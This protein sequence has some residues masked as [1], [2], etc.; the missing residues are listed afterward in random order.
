MKFTT[1]NILLGLGIAFATYFALRAMLWTGPVERGWVLVTCA[2]AVLVVTLLSILVTPSATTATPDAP[3]TAGSRGPSQM[4][5]GIA[6]L[7][8]VVAAIV[9]TAVMTSVPPEARELSYATTFLGAIGVLLTVVVI[10]RRTR[11][12]WCGVALLA[13]GAIVWL[14]PHLALALGLTGS[15]MW[16]LTAQLLLRGL[17]RLARDSVRLVELQHAA[18]AWGRSQ[19]ARR[20]ERRV[21]VQFALRTAGPV[22]ERVIASG[23]ELNAAERLQARVAEGALRDYLR[24][25]RLLDQDVRRE[26]DAARARGIAVTMVDDGGLD[27]ISGAEL[28]EIRQQLAQAIAGAESGRLIIRTSRRAETAVSVVGRSNASDSDE[29]DVSL[30]VEIAR[31]GYETP[32]AS[33]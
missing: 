17:D 9:P 20:R 8:I 22:L 6:M 15:V 28:R 29:D 7:S 25:G 10:R 5:L 11:V 19:D 13:I 27:L 1:R 18:V 21:R 16:V 14:G 33:P 4:P 26:L 31:P 23:G 24:G 30:W 2:V 12:A 32:E 3:L